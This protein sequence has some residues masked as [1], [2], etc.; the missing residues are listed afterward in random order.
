MFVFKVPSFVHQRLRYASKYSVPITRMATAFLISNIA[1][2]QGFTY[3]APSVL[4]DMQRSEFRPRSV[5][6]PRVGSFR[7]GLGSSYGAG[8]TTQVKQKKTS[9][10][11]RESERRVGYVEFFLLPMQKVAGLY[12]DILLFC[13][14]VMYY[15]QGWH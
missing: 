8:I 2:L 12:R 5:R 6:R 1:C 10:C 3:V 14:T 15:R 13:G 9:L 11:Q 7:P 4:E